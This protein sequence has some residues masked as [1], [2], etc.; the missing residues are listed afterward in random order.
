MKQ[1]QKISKKEEPKKK[2]PPILEIPY[3]LTNVYIQT[4]EVWRTH[5]LRLFFPIG[6][7]R[8]CSIVGF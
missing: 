3:Y 2:Q 1:D 4:A 8:D 5:Y 7:S 6:T